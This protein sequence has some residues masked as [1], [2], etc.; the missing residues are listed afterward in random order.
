MPEL[1]DYSVKAIP[2]EKIIETWEYCFNKKFNIRYFNWRFLNNPN[3]TKVYVKYIMENGT[4]AA[5]YAVSPMLLKK[6]NNGVIK[7]ALANMTMTHPDYRGKGYTRLL[8]LKLYAQLKE[9][10]YACIF[11]YP[12]RKAM[13]HIFRKHLNFQ[14][15][16]IL[17]TMYLSRGNF[18]QKPA[19]NYTVEHGNVNDEIIEIVQQ[20]TFTD[21]KL[22]LLRDKPNLK[23]RLIDNPTNNYRYLKISCNNIIRMVIFYKLHE[24]SADIIEYC[25]DAATYCPAS[26]FPAGLVYLFRLARPEITGINIWTSV[27]SNEFHFLQD[28]Q[29]VPDSDNTYFGII[30]LNEDK[31]LLGKDCWH[32]RYFDSDI[33]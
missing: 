2:Q 27:D 22:S 3:E 7:V 19:N 31:T 30:P 6:R 17:K 21:K 11:S 14:D 20:L 1:I 15:V 18:K 25:Y 13:H 24:K 26:D 28:L 5:H 4:L 33:Y 12:V 32:N 16:T 29:F 8:A 10:D 23:W 9:D